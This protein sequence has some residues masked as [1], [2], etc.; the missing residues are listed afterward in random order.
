[1]KKL[2]ATSSI[3]FALA[4]GASTGVIPT[5][6]H[7]ANYENYTGF[8]ID[9]TPVLPAAET[10]PS[11]W[12][13]ADGIAE[14]RA[15]R[16]QD[17]VAARLW[18]K[19]A[20]SPFA[21]DPIPALPTETDKTTLHKYFGAMS[22][23]AITSGLLY[24]GTEDAAEREAWRLRAVEVLLRAYDGPLYEIDPRN[25]STAA[26]EIYRGTWAQNYAAAYDWV[27]PTLTPEQDTA[28]RERLAREAAYM[29]EN[30][31]DWASRPHNHLSKPAWGLATLELALSDHPDA[32][33][34]L[35]LA[36]QASN[37]NTRY[38]FSSDGIYREGSH[39]YIFSL[40]NFVPFLYHYRN[41]SGV[42]AFDA[43]QPAFEWPV[44]IRNGKGWIPNI[45]DSYIR[46]FPSR[47][48]SGAYRNATSRFGAQPSFGAILQWN[49]D[50]TD[51]VPFE[52]EEKESG[53]NYSG[54]SWDYALPTT[55]FLCYDPSVKPA[56]PACSPTV[57]LDSGQ[58]AFRNDWSFNDPAHRYLLF[59]GVAE[60]DNHEHFEHLS[61]LI[62]A[63]N[64]MMAS[65]A[66]YSRKSYGEAIRTQWYRT[67]EAHNVVM[68]DGKAPG[69]IAENWT[70]PS[71]DRIDTSF[72]DFEEKSAAYASGGTHARAIAFPGQEYFV[73][74]DRIQLP[75]PGEI[76]FVFHGGRAALDN[77]GTQCTWTYENDRYGPTAKLFSHFLSTGAT[78]AR[79]EGEVTYIKGD[80][81]AFP[82]IT[83]TLNADEALFLS[84]FV[85]AAID[86]QAPAI[87]SLPCSGG[88]IGA[89]VTR[90]ET[91]DTFVLQPAPLAN[92][93]AGLS[94]D[95]RFAWMREENGRAA[96]LFAQEAKS[97]AA[98]GGFALDVSEPSSFAVHLASNGAIEI[99]LSCASPLT[100]R[101]AGAPANAAATFQGERIDA[102]REGNALVVALP[103]GGKLL[104][105]EGSK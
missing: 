63:E 83:N 64:Q 18:S 20:E 89:R 71:R 22:Q 29:H 6:L 93:T 80:Y 95:G 42:D 102:K 104:I 84:V 98:P 43:F 10:H 81:A 39:Y 55:E 8:A 53:F 15:R 13:D 2:T 48:V 73:V 31:Y 88:A 46:P 23:I 3:A 32:K 4:L 70:P 52:L 40:I 66:G 67:P 90:G 50:A 14:L 78:L 33:D 21:T 19:I 7:A 41:V 91:R 17:E 87:E 11:L 75:Q 59:Q 97:I 82:Y 38:F 92:E 77:N 99:D 94:S 56:P 62:Q 79:K 47:M 37:D 100:L 27:Q 51:F 30:L 28:I 96:S 9:E 35:A 65:D 5:T 86:A 105:T 44:A 85:P 72:F 57:F 101:V 45:E 24:M 69:D 103:A 49:G 1:M 58:T 60:A 34:W 25:S 16:T 54:A 74:A 26:D 12:F 61:F 68:V 76:A 36:L